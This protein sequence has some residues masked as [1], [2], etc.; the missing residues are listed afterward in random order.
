[1]QTNRHSIVEAGRQRETGRQ[2]DIHSKILTD[3]QR[4]IR[5]TSI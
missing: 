1:M 3:R 2:T 5:Q 4:K